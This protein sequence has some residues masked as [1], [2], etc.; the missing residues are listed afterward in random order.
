MNKEDNNSF[1]KFRVLFDKHNKK[2]NQYLTYYF[3]TGHPG[4]TMED[5]EELSIQL[6]KLKNTEGVQLF[7]PTPMTIS[8]C[9]YYTGLNPF[10]LEKIYVPYTY[11]EKKKQKNALY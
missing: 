8:T 11:N 4:S 3:M 2:L 1:E 7:T 9:M 10:T 6:K 5:V